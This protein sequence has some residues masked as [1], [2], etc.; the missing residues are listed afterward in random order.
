MSTIINKL[1]FFLFSFLIIIFFCNSRLSAS[2]FTNP[3]C[4]YL[5]HTFGKGIGFDEGYTTIEYMTFPSW[6]CCKNNF[7][8]F[9]DARLHVFDNGKLATNAGIGFRIQPRN[10]TSF[11][12]FNVFY[13]FRQGS[14]NFDY[15]QIGLGLEFLNCCF[16]LRLNSY[17]PI[18]SKN[19]I[20]CCIF[21]DYQDGYFIKKDQVEAA[22][23]GITLDVGKY[24]CCSPSGSTYVQA[25]AYY[26]KRNKATTAFGGRFRVDVFVKNLFYFG[27]S[28]S[29]DSQ[30]DT[31]VSG[32]IGIRYC[33]GGSYCF[34]P[35][36][37]LPNRPIC[38]DE[39]IIL[40]NYCE[41]EWNY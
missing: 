6:L 10:Y 8:T 7:W 17:I 13:D 32:R 1:L 39:L 29:H 35:V 34:D 37:C 5:D 25:G 30:F 21:D 38:R 31:R 4:I 14:H 23:P 24:I 36:E 27:G 16:D 19:T 41:W 11:F 3:S 40:D 33:F 22:F 20:E 26:Y 28:I 12:G 18:D 15:N 9:V 2:C